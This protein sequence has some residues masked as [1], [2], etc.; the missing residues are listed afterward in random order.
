MD[1]STWAHFDPS[2]RGKPG[3][4]FAH[5]HGIEHEK[6]L[7]ETTWEETG[8]WKLGQ[9]QER[10]VSQHFTTTLTWRQTPEQDPGLTGEEE[11]AYNW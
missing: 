9:G 1:T 2:P 5:L 3:L 8:M 11:C 10:A 4:L 7:E 6:W